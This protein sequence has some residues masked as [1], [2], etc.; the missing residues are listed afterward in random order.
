[1][2]PYANKFIIT[3][4]GTNQPVH[5]LHSFFKYVSFWNI[6][7]TQLSEFCGQLFVI[8]VSAKFAHTYLPTI[9]H[10]RIIAIILSCCILCN[11][12]HVYVGS[13]Q[14]FP[15][16]KQLSYSSNS[17]FILFPIGRIFNYVLAD[18]VEIFFIADDV[19]VKRTLPYFDIGTEIITH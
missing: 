2:G 16:W 7:N 5:F 8:S 18:S 15:K 6:L 9:R 19:V 10:F 17:I 3:H 14:V 13:Y 1:M 11:N 4:T 12:S